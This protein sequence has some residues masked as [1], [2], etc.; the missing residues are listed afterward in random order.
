MSAEKYVRFELRARNG[1]FGPVRD[2]SGWYDP[3]PP[4]CAST[5]V[6]ISVTCPA[7][8][9]FKGNGCFAQAAKF[10]IP[11]PGPDDPPVTALDISLAEAEVIKR[12]AMKRDISTN[13][14]PDPRKAKG[15]D[16]RLHEGG[17]VSCEAGARALAEAAQ[18]WKDQGGDAVWCY[19]HRWEWIPRD[20]WGP[21]SVFASVEEPEEIEEAAA[22]GYPAALTVREFEN[23]SR[24]FSLP[25]TDRM[26]IPCPEEVDPRHHCVKCRACLDKDILG[27]KHAAIAFAVHGQEDK[28]AKKARSVLRVIGQSP[29]R[30]RPA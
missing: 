11:E 6:L 16:L 3:L 25:E 14:H 8:C 21:I 15:L 2:R 17:D 18:V 4:F 23:G 19:T 13:N 7:T 26:I 24:V 27:Q 22:R 28:T 5:S 10:P 30:G 29:W 1:K 12:E 20:A 9:R